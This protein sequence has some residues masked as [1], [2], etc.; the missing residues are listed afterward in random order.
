[1]NTILLNRA[2]VLF[3]LFAVFTA[4]ALAADLKAGKNTAAMCQGC[5]GAEGVSS[6]PMW[7]SLAGQ[8]A[9]YLEKQLNAFKSGKRVNAT[10]KGMVAALDKTAIENVSAYF[11]SLPT[12]SAGGD[13]SLA[14][15]GEEKATMC[16]GCHGN[17][18]EGRGQFP[19]LAG[20]HPQYL[21]KQ[22]NSFKSGERKGGPMNAVVKNLSE[23]DIKEISAY[24][25]S[26]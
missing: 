25:G 14:K 5:H 15:K 21:A 19:K 11:A 18:A 20:Q 1:M 12:K 23:Q 16:M 3:S 6:N 2:A 13:A 4:N 10:M 8:K 24:L 26:L 9:A 22:L 17:N 7:P